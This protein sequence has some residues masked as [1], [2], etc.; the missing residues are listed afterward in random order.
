M[1]RCSL[2]RDCDWGVWGPET[3]EAQW[4]GT[5]FAQRGWARDGP[6]AK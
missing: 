2:F 4:A 6:G 5:G 1:V 3:P